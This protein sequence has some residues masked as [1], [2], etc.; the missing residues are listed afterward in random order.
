MT[1]SRRMAAF[2]PFRTANGPEGRMTIEQ[3]VD[4]PANHRI[5]L[6]LPGDVPTGK[7]KVT[8]VPFAEPSVKMGKRLQDAFSPEE[9]KAAK[10]LYGMFESDGHELDR[11]LERK[12]ADKTL[13]TEI[14]G[15]RIQ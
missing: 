8:I 14:E 11:F 4:I 9:L 1:F 3:T 6:D 10:P 7:A 13:E 12:R 2:N 5:Y 15:R